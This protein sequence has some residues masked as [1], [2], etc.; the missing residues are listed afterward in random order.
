VKTSPTGASAAASLS[1]PSE[2]TPSSLVTRMRW[3]V[4]DV[5]S[6]LDPTTPGEAELS[7]R[8]RKVALSKT[9][10]LAASLWTALFSAANLSDPKSVNAETPEVRRSGPDWVVLD[11]SPINGKALALATD[12]H[13]AGRL[14]ATGQGVFRSDDFGET[15]SLLNQDLRLTILV[16]DP[17]AR[18][19]LF[20]VGDFL[21]RS[22]DAGAT[23]TRIPD[24]PTAM[25]SFLVD[26]AGTL[27]ADGPRGVFKS[28]NAGDNWL[29]A[30]SVGWL[31]AADP[32]TPGLLYGMT[33]GDFGG[34]GIFKS[35]DGALSWTGPLFTTGLLEFVGALTMSS[36]EPATVY[37]QTSLRE[38]S[39]C[40][41]TVQASRDGGAT[42]RA[43]L[44]TAN[45]GPIATDPVRPD[46]LYEGTSPCGSSPAPGGVYQASSSGRFEPLGRR[47]FVAQTLL[48]APDGSRL[49]AIAGEKL[50]TLRLPAHPTTTGIP[51]R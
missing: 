14:Y 23:W 37:L 4:I 13:R 43:I 40:I 47:G 24:P 5:D 46:V 35:S 22:D 33:C 12:P 49:Y 36:T 39:V 42:W 20:A 2:K 21:W 3:R 6:S 48:A 16:A 27:Y 29:P 1:I 25:A 51:F 44:S 15:W 31:F 28:T 18:D 11:Q 45:V 8:I 19:R 41:G 50:A 17:S 32:R 30:S 10:L 38:H 7:L 9:F 34:C 26:A